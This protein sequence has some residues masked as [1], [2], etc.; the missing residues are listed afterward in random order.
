MEF[1]DK[2][3][4][5][6]ESQR[7][8]LVQRLDN[9]EHEKR[10]PHD[11][12]SEEQ[13]IER[14]NDEVLNSLD[15]SASNELKNINNALERIAAEQYQCCELCGEDIPEARLVA[16]PYAARCIDCADEK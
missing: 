11:P 15:T 7:E 12:D 4:Q 2:M 3:R 8:D 14:E 13:A 10:M 5:V 9:I 6:L 16:V 1:V